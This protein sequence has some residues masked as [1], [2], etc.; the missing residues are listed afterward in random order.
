[1]R[2][3]T[4]NAVTLGDLPGPIGIAR[5]DRHR[6]EAGLPIGDQMAVGHDETSPDAPNAEIAALRHPW[7]EVEIFGVVHRNGSVC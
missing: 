4:F 7:E 1:M 6:M 3:G 5:R 2:V